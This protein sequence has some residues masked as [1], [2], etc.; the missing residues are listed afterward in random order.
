MALGKTTKIEKQRAHFINLS[1]AMTKAIHRFG[2]NQKVYQQFCPMANNNKGATWL[3]YE[4]EIINPYF[5]KVMLDCGNT[6]S[7]IN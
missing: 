5:G 4:M 7:E 6:V 3:S 1:N 2:I